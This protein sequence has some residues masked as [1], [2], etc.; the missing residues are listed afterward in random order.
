MQNNCTNVIAVDPLSIAK[1][2]LYNLSK[3]NNVENQ[4]KFYRFITP[5]RLNNLLAK[6]E[7]AAS[8]ML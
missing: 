8:S 1:I 5:S 6:G 7:L 2:N 4:I 3:D